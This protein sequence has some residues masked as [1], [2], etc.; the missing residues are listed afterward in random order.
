VKIR[1]KSL[2]RYLLSRNIDFSDTSQLAQAKRDY[3]RLYNKQWRAT[4]NKCKEIRSKFTRDEFF[5]LEVR[6]HLYGY[7]S[8]TAYTRA[9]MLTNFQNVELAPDKSELRLLLKTISQAINANKSSIALELLYEAEIL[10][11]SYL[12]N[13]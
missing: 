3:V 8:V 6:A 9:V 7:K 11:L 2:L 13:H 10:L 1:S 4:A 12:K 5:Q